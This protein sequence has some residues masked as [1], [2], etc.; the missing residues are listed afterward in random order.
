MS[1]NNPQLPS[2]AQA[3]NGLSMEHQTAFSSKVE[4][5]TP[6]PGMVVT[7][8]QINNNSHVN[9]VNNADK[10]QSMQS[11]QQHNAQYSFPK[12]P[13]QQNE[14]VMNLAASQ[15]V[16]EK[17]LMSS[18]G[19][20]ILTSDV[21][22][23]E[24]TPKKYRGDRDKEKE[25]KDKKN[26]IWQEREREWK[27]LQQQRQQENRKQQQQNQD[28]YPMRKDVRGKQSKTPD[29]RKTTTPRDENTNNLV[30]EQHG[31]TVAASSNDNTIQIQLSNY[32]SSS[33][34]SRVD[35]QVRHPSVMSVPQAERAVENSQ[36]TPSFQI[37][38]VAVT[39]STPSVENSTT[40]WSQDTPPD[41][42]SSLQ[43]TP[44]R[45]TSTEVQHQNWMGQHE[46]QQQHTQRSMQLPRQMSE[47]EL[48]QEQH[49]PVQQ[50][51][52]SFQH[53]SA[54][55]LNV[56]QVP[57]PTPISSEHEP[58][59]PMSRDPSVHPSVTQHLAMTRLDLSAAQSKQSDNTFLEQ[60]PR[61]KQQEALT[62]KQQQVQQLQ[63][64]QQLQQQEVLQRE[65]RKQLALAQ[66]QQQG[67]IQMQLKHHRFPSQQPYATPQPPRQANQFTANSKEMPE[68]DT[69]EEHQERL[70]FLYRQRQ[71]QKQLQAR[72]YMMQPPTPAPSNMWVNNPQV[73]QGLS[74]NVPSDPIQQRL[75]LEQQ[76][77]SQR[78]DL[79]RGNM[80]KLP[81]HISSAYN[82]TP[83]PV[84]DA[85]QK[86][87]FH[88]QTKNGQNDSEFLAT[89]QVTHT[90]VSISTYSTQAG[91]TGH[92]TTAAI[93][94]EIAAAKSD[95]RKSTRKDRRNSTIDL[96]SHSGHFGAGF[97]N[98]VEPE[99][100]RDGSA[101]SHSGNN[102]NEL[103]T[104][105][106]E[107]CITVDEGNVRR[108]DAADT[109]FATDNDKKEQSVGE[110]L[111]GK[112]LLLPYGT[113]NSALQ[114]NPA[115]P[116]LVV[117]PPQ[118][119][120]SPQQQHML[121]QAQQQQLLWQQAHSQL[122]HQYQLLYQQLQQLQ[123]QLQQTQDPA[124]H[125]QVLGNQQ[126]LRFLQTQIL[127]H[128]QQGQ[129][130]VQQI[131]LQAFG[132][133]AM[134][135]QMDPTQQKH[136]QIY[137]Q[138][139]VRQQQQWAQQFSGVADIFGRVPGMPQDNR[140]PAVEVRK[141]VV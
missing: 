43:R 103:L 21:S 95:N 51:P 34:P 50:E 75:F 88:Q 33:Q 140:P 126:Q 131:H 79:Q 30:T 114:N 48:Q 64:Q 128:W 97:P 44:S 119:S 31:Q 94:S 1:S 37:Q 113:P 46:E 59:R 99:P 91:V 136:M 111:N 87:I 24:R 122:Q 141:Y 45:T 132:V 110:D 42:G 49:Q 105:S 81:H 56:V 52:S 22:K 23:K 85:T 25:L 134:F 86:F 73:M 35:E 36:S 92:T 133:N 16:A 63:K 54:L 120:L 137:Q 29:W 138:E 109:G 123:I 14:S 26:Q 82:T 20:H 121:L 53:Q 69:E 8:H 7:N 124:L 6:Y 57:V 17:Q 28:S 107:T 65:Q 13:F 116:Q 27:L 135:N 89:P 66:H 9:I 77:P 101:L 10:S 125:Q 98:A 129:I 39:T 118:L 130:V 2:E 84:A 58:H 15:P 5:E 127:R 112:S 72:Q 62:Q 68:I 106:Q 70:Q 74:Q 38:T 41:S 12:H 4:N 71:M 78:L 139:L 19:S 104:V 11:K 115:N 96:S 117:P 60:T 32:I 90:Q 40:F 102:K 55:P 61:Q 108:V 47:H 83:T 3:V 100:Q 18:Q 80:E 67:F 76:R 93:F